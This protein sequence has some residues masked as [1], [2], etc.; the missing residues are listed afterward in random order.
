[1]E[2]NLYSQSLTIIT[3]LILYE[4]TPEFSIKSKLNNLISISELKKD[5]FH[6]QT[7]TTKW[8][9]ANSSFLKAQNKKTEDQ[10]FPNTH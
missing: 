7:K 5:S 3:P 1:M 2:L 8:G 10:E 4:K 6:P 9:H